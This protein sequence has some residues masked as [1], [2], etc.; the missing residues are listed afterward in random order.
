[1]SANLK[2][3]KFFL[4]GTFLGEGQRIKDG[5]KII[6]YKEQ[7]TFDVNRHFPSLNVH[8]QAKATIPG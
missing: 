1:M 5:N 3:K 8:W 4:E 6:D 2:D 7:I